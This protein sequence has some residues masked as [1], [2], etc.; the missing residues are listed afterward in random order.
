MPKVS[1]EHMERRRQQILAAAKECFTKD[2]FHGTSMQDIFQASGLSAGAVY[3]YFPSKH[4]LI[5][6]LAEET[7][8]SALA[9]V[10][11]E[12]KPGDAG[13]ML[14]VIARGLGNGGPLAEAGAIAVQVWAE[15]FRDPE[16][17]AIARDVLG[18]FLDRIEGW[19]PAGAPPEMARLIL[20]TLQGFVIQS[21]IFGD[22]TPELIASAA[23]ATFRCP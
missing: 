11:V 5:K 15:A 13:E 23:D 16:M 8:T 17:A 12:E 10:D 9:P 19:L 2:G 1:Q 7:L 18:L 22:V 6:A 20:A 4:L 21:G 14:K 3:R